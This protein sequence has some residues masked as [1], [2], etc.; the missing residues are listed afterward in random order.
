MRRL[1]VLYDAECSLCT[2]V[3]DWLLRQPRLVTLELVPEA[4][5]EARGGFPG[6]TTR[7]PWTR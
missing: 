1:A 4:S 7:P 3:R 2:H 5:D 6:S